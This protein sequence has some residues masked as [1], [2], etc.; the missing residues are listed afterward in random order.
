MYHITP[1]SRPDSPGEHD[2]AASA[3]EPRFGSMAGNNRRSMDSDH[4]VLTTSPTVEIRPPLATS[5]AIN[6]SPHQRQ[7]TRRNSSLSRRSRTT[8]GGSNRN[9]RVF[10]E[11]TPAPSVTISTDNQRFLYSDYSRTT[12]Q[13]HTSWSASEGEES[14][15][16]T[17]SSTANISPR[18]SAYLHP[19]DDSPM[20]T[21]APEMTSLERLRKGFQR[22]HG[23]RR[24]FLCEL[25]SIRRKSR[26]GRQGL[27]ELKDYDKN[28]SVVRDVLHEG[29]AGIDELVDDLSKVLDTELYTL[30]RIDPQSNDSA[31]DK[32]VQPFVHRL[33]SLEQH[34]RGVQ[35]KIYIC[36]EDIKEAICHDPMDLEKQ[37]LLELQ[38]ES[39]SEDI[40]MMASEWQYGK[41]ALALVMD[42]SS[43]KATS[44]FNHMME[45]DL[46][47]MHGAGLP[48]LGEAGMGPV[49]DSMEQPDDEN[50]LLSLTSKREEVFE[51]ST[52]HELSGM[53]RGTTA[54]G[55]KMTRA[56]RIQHQ[57]AL[58]EQEEQKKAKTYNSTRMVHELKDVLGRRRQLREGVDED[59]PA[60]ARMP[61]SQSAP[62]LS[63]SATASALG[64]MIDTVNLESLSEDSSLSVAGSSPTLLCSA[65]TNTTNT[66]MLTAVEEAQQNFPMEY[67]SPFSLGSSVFEDQGSTTHHHQYGYK[68]VV[69]FDDDHMQDANDNAFV[70]IS[71]VGEAEA[72]MEA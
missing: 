46:A 43:S 57:R 65:T 13:H 44:H 63:S 18:S 4:M 27:H 45:D 53:S 37:R 55:P 8:A 29:M 25:L 50:A 62:I 31:Q 9:S 54:T 24:E 22:M 7:H 71:G 67:I 48:Y 11:S 52:E 35:A 47:E 59:E 33:A 20:M 6:T 2:G 70:E 56:E 17:G 72:E 36:N 21:G 42:P 34:I 12:R 19:G 3:H 15:S 16:A 41:S 32:R 51:A 40:S 61:H 23:Y 68:S 66:T 30:P 1:S 49:I 10:G 5:I 28:W 39:I 14:D 58:R 60:H 26:K 64:I 38:Y 69:R